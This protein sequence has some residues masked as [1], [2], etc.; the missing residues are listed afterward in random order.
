MDHA[1]KSL[2][3]E[4]SLFGNILLSSY[5]Q[6]GCLETKGTWFENL[7]EYLSEIGVSLE[8]GGNH[9]FKPVRIGD[10]SLMGLFLQNFMDHRQAA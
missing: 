2:Q 1:Y 7:W 9:H 5:S 10:M 3:M 6:Y 4:V 8:L